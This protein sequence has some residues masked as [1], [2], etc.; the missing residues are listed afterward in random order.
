MGR[1]FLLNISRYGFISDVSLILIIICC[2]VSDESD[3]SIVILQ[4]VVEDKT[5]GVKLI[6][7][8][9]DIFIVWLQKDKN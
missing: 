8:G 3:L 6:D 2:D 9:D 4:H 5:V 1:I 7:K